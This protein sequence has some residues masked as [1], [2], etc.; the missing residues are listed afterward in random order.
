MK[1]V[2]AIPARNSEKTIGAVYHDIPAHYQNHVLMS[3]DGSTDATARVA[4]KLGI[5]VFR[6]PRQP[7][8]GSNVKNCFIQALK[9]GADIVI[10]LHSDNQYDATKIPQLVAPI[11]NN[12]A[13][14]TIGSRILGDRAQGMSAF[15]FIGNRFL[16]L[17]ENLIMG[18]KIT[19]LHSGLIAVR[20]DVLKVIPFRI[21][22]D[23]YGFHTDVVLQSHYVG[24]RFKEVGI[25]TRY[26]DVSTSISIYKSIIYGFSTLWT[27][28]KY[29]CNR[30]RIIRSPQFIMRGRLKT[31]QSQALK[32]QSGSRKQ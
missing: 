8:Y 13:D 11:E 20:A 26:E 4:Q 24:A 5:K 23:D 17:M 6:N 9:L 27:L 19:D 31:Q 1:V 7:G 3:D 18:T 29:A 32:D 25:P 2:I 15:R 16:G 21:D 10:I 28:L 30:S 12:Q 22:S 14:F